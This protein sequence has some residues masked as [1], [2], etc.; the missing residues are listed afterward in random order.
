MVSGRRVCSFTIVPVL[1]AACGFATS[2]SAASESFRA[3]GAEFEARR[4]VALSPEQVRPVVVVEFL[5]HSL[6]RPD[7]RNVLVVAQDGQPVPTRVLQV[8][9]G[10][11]CRVAFET[12]PRTSAYEILYGG[13][14]P[15]ADRV[16]RWTNPDGLLLEI[17]QLRPCDLNQFEAVRQAFESAEPI[18]ADYVPTVHH[19]TNPMTLAQGPMMSRYHGRL[20]LDREGDYT[21][22]TSSQD[23][24]FLLIDGK[25][26]VEAPGRHGPLWQ[27]RPG[28]GKTVH[29]AAGAH[30]FDYYHAATGPETMMAAAWSDA[31]EETKPRPTVIPAEAFCGGS[32]GRA[33]AGPV[34]TRARRHVPDFKAAVTGDVPLPDEP[35]AMIGVV[36]ENTSP[37]A[38]SAGAKLQWDFGDGQTSVEPRVGHVY[39]RPGVYRV[40]LS[41][42]RGAQTIE[43]ANRIEVD[44]PLGPR[45]GQEKPHTLDEYLPVVKTYD[46]GRLD[47]ASLRQLVLA[48]Q[49][50]SHLIREAR[51]ATRAEA[52]ANAAAE[53]ESAAKSQSDKAPSRG[54]VPKKPPRAGRASDIRV[55]AEAESEDEARAYLVAAVEA[56][57][58]P[59]VAPSAAGSDE[60]LV[61][62]AELVG[63]IARVELGDAPSALVIWKGAAGR[64]TDA[65]L[66]AHCQVR[67]ADVARNDLVDVPTAARLV[68]AAAATSSGRLGGSPGARLRRVEGDLLASRGEGPQ[69]CEAYRQAQSL[70]NRRHAGPEEIAQRGAFSR[71]TEQ[72]LRAEDWARAAAELGAWQE[73]FPEDKIDGYL[74]LLWAQYWF[75]RGQYPQAIALCQQLQAVNPASPWADQLL[76]LAAQAELKRGQGDRA[77]ATLHSLLKDYPGSP[78]VPEARRQLEMLKK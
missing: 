64:I 37:P 65:N 52:E 7:G 40:S 74:T 21:F 33:E 77:A 47:A 53:A 32:I 19:A 46:L 13:D 55:A 59:F 70:C 5:H 15:A 63:S 27:A 22:W 29:L 76:W 75:G 8:G 54:P 68:E 18:G 38:L 28:T 73:Q 31:P 51:A 45:P 9:P 23:C 6:V 34:A 35:L 69:A 14:P 2:A 61:A 36:F 42:R 71:S 62:L 60:D 39:L 4:P 56:G 26:V 11:F 12:V 3:A 78:L 50:K 24:S 58:T 49:W 10:D 30:E 44:R 25:I 57:K 72:F 16:P 67:A 41:I 48:Y 66:R 20:H 17:R 1:L 43:T